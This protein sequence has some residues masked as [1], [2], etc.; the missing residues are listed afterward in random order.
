MKIQKSILEYNK[1]LAIYSGLDTIIL[2]EQGIIDHIASLGQSLDEVKED[3]SDQFESFATLRDKYF[4]HVF[5]LIPDKDKVKELTQ[6]IHDFNRFY[7]EV[8]AQ[9][10]QYLDLYNGHPSV[11]VVDNPV[12]D[13][14]TEKI[15]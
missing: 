5:Y 1:Q 2:F 9:N 6:S 4:D 7:E 10:K 14:Q 11:F 8:K 15:L 13:H 3:I 12:Y